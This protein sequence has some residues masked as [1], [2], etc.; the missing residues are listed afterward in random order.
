MAAPAYVHNV[1]MLP[2]NNAEHFRCRHTARSCVRTTAFSCEQHCVESPHAFTPVRA[3]RNGEFDPTFS[4]GGW[5]G[6]T[7][8][9]PTG[10]EQSGDYDQR[11]P[12]VYADGSA[13][14][15]GRT[16]F[17]D[18]SNGLDYIS[19]VRV[20]FDLVFADQQTKGFRPPS[21]VSYQR[22]TACS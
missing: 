9:D 8:A 13:L 22:V 19:I 10:S 3:D 4:N 2:S 17:E 16:F 21:L 15:F 11:P 5:R 12:M 1:S 6:Y 20:S 7:I 18:D 14:L